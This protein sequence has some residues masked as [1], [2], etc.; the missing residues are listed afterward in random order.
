MKLCPQITKD[1]TE[2]LTVLQCS[3]APVWVEAAAAI[4]R[5]IANDLEAEVAAVRET[6]E[7]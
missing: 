3:P 2:V 1:L 7:S 4:L 6:D 5:R